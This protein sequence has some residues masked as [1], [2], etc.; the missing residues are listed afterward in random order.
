MQNLK[1]KRKVGLKLLEKAR[2]PMD[3]KEIS[4]RREVVATTDMRK[5]QAGT[6]KEEMVH[7]EEETTT[8]KMVRRDLVDQTSSKPLRKPNR[9]MEEKGTDVN[10]LKPLSMRS[11]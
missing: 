1:L 10:D 8:V 9:A 11:K 5:N 6:T 7:I 3:S 2:D 4:R